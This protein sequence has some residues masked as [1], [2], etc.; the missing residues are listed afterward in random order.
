MKCAGGRSPHQSR[1]ARHAARPRGGGD[2]VRPQPDELVHGRRGRSPTPPQLQP[3]CDRV[4]PM[5]RINEYREALRARPTREHL[6]APRVARPSS[7][8]RA[9]SQRRTCAPR[10]SLITGRG[11]NPTRR[12]RNGGGVPRFRGRARA[13]P[14]QLVERDGRAPRSCI[15][16]RPIRVGGSAKPWRWPAQR[17]TS[18][19]FGPR[20]TSG[21]TAPGS[22]GALPL[23]R[24]LRRPALLTTAERVGEACRAC[25]G[26]SGTRGVECR[27]ATVGGSSAAQRSSAT[28]GAWR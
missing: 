20:C 6:L 9:C 22:S 5:S 28:A 3:G 13:G 25:Q 26:D 17:P 8:P 7:E 21:R 2:F 19:R 14:G 18:G 23:R 1:A 24:P 11:W 16:M 27:G 4:H 12:R 15:A 10:A